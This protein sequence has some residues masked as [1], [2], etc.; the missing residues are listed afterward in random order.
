MKV[1]SYERARVMGVILILGIARLLLENDNLAQSSLNI[2][3]VTTDRF[4]EVEEHCKSV[5]SKA[6][7]WLSDGNLWVPAKKFSLPLSGEWE[8]EMGSAPLLPLH[9][10]KEDKIFK[11]A[12]LSLYPQV[13]DFLN[14]FKR[15][16]ISKVVNLTASLC[17]PIS[18]NKSSPSNNKICRTGYENQPSIP[19]L[20][21]SFQGIF[22]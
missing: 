3:A 13:S 16:Q 19:Q 7:P 9:F 14:G 22:T 8:Q 4:T 11:L 20:Y 18:N 1:K 10:Q 17:L 15:S 12:S 21:M 2:V 5:A 6:S